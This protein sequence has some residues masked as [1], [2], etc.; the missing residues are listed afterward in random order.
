V[1]VTMLSAA[2]PEGIW[3]AAGFPRPSDKP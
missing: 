2:M 1:L 3:V